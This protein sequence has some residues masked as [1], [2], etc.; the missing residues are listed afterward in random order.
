MKSIF[1]FSFFT[2]KYFY[3]TRT[4]SVEHTY[5]SSIFI[6]INNDFILYLQ[7]I[8]IMD[9]LKGSFV[10]LNSAYTGITGPF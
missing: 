8:L 3:Y 1:C 7:V 2:H 10:T 6:L 5:K 4:D 9:F